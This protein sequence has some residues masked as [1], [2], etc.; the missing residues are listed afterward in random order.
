[1][2]KCGFPG[3]NRSNHDYSISLLL[4]LS[5]E[6]HGRTRCGRTE[7]HAASRSGI[8]LLRVEADNWLAEFKNDGLIVGTTV[9]YNTDID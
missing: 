3:C 9:S 6:A 7:P 5:P 2:G 8:I 1:M 4:T